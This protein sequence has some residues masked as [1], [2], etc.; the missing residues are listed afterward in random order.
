MPNTRINVWNTIKLFKFVCWLLIAPATTLVMT[1]ARERPRHTMGPPLSPWQA[2]VTYA[3]LQICHLV[4]GM[5][6][7]FIAA[8]HVCWFTMY[9]VAYSSVDET[10]PPT[11]ILISIMQLSRCKI[12]WKILIP[13]PL[14]ARAVWSWFSDFCLS[15]RGKK[16]PPQN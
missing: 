8:A 16:T 2:A 15:P 10:G 1:P 9:T 11:F 14:K 5:P 4:S 3:E 12:I 7:F 13:H 6:Y